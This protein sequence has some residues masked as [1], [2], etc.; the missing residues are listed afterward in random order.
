MKSNIILL[1]K[2]RNVQKV[3]NTRLK[4]ASFVFSRFKHIS[5]HLKPIYLFLETSWQA[6]IKGRKHVRNITRQEEWKKTALSSVYV[7][8]IKS[9]PI[10]ELSLADYF[11]KFGS[12]KK[13]TIDKTSV[14]IWY[15]FW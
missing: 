10:A 7:C 2:G 6:H 11:S 3:A 4:F 8:G 9:L 15:N 1:E 13:I 5:L 14:I 12:V